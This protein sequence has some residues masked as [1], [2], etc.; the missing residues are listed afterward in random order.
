MKLSLQGINKFFQIA[1]L[2][3][4]GWCQRANCNLPTNLL[5]GYGAAERWQE[6]SFMSPQGITDTRAI[7]I[8]E[9]REIW[10]G[11]K[12]GEDTQQAFESSLF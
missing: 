12:W 10:R 4:E 3:Q 1:F 5:Q 8:E 9:S 6:P 11:G 7:T 2:L